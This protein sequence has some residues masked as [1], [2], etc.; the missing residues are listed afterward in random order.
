M[1]ACV[2]YYPYVKVPQSAWFTRVLL[3]WDEV[4][5]IVPSD[6]IQNPDRLG[7]YMVGLL[8]EQLVTQVIPGMY[9]STVRNFGESF[10]NY[11]DQKARKP[12]I[13]GERRWTRVHM[14]KLQ[15]VGEQLCVRGLARKDGADQYSPWYEVERET[16]HKFMAYLAAV[17]GQLPEPDKFYPI[18]DHEVRLKPFLQKSR[19]DARIRDN[20]LRKLILDRILPAPCGAIE[21]AR[22][23]DFKAS[24][25]SELQR[26]RRELEDS[27]SELSVIK[28]EKD[29]RMRLNIIL[30]GMKETV[31]E[32]KVRMEQ[33]R[34]WPHV[35]FGV[36]CAVIGTGISAWKAII[37]QD[38]QFGMSGAALSLAAAVYNAFR[39]SN[40]DFQDKPLAYAALAERTFVKR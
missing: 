16:A 25:K 7:K 5:A 1:K 32:L 34:N 14:E 22:L 28:D 24:H 40:L 26:F 6:H 3:Y 21:P 37:D 8:Q 19:Q 17:L 12:K 29:R 38:W 39:D 4:G 33:Q 23:A 30:G 15:Q 11:V 13:G 10:I 2:L 36:L 31:R 18:T 9:L 35:D 20:P 27:I